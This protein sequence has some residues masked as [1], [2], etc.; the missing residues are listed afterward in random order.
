MVAES[1]FGK[2]DRKV[3]VD[4]PIENARA[5]GKGEVV[6]AQILTGPMRAAGT[7]RQYFRPEEKETMFLFMGFVK[8]DE[9]SGGLG[10]VGGGTARS[11]R[12][13]EPAATIGK[14]S[15]GVEIRH[16][17]R[18]VLDRVTLGVSNHQ[19]ALFLINVGNEKVLEEP[20]ESIQIKGHF[21]RIDPIVPHRLQN[22]ADAMQLPVSSDGAAVIPPSPS[23]GEIGKHARYFSAKVRSLGSLR[24][25]R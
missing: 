3:F 20:P 22:H 4:R 25:F 24:S 19:I 6:R 7:E 11:H 23:S 18:V 14:G 8:D 10:S 15:G 16:A 5:V 21:L 12:S 1:K 9:T 2:H 13:R 17:G